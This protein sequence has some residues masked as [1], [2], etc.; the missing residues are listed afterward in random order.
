VIGAKSL[1]IERKSLDVCTIPCGCR[2]PGAGASDTAKNA[3]THLPYV[4]LGVVLVGG[5]AGIIQVFQ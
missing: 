3:L 1:G 5:V 4:F 2:C